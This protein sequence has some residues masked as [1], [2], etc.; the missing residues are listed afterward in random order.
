M[1]STSISGIVSGNISLSVS[2]NVL[3]NILEYKPECKYF[4]TRIF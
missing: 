2:G 4:R 3:P 1:V